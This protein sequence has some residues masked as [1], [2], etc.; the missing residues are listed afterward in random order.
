MGSFP[1]VPVFSNNTISEYFEYVKYNLK[2]SHNNHFC[3]LKRN[4]VLSAKLW[5][6]LYHHAK[7]G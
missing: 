1:R 7:L 3:N 5:V 4:K 6:C 2:D